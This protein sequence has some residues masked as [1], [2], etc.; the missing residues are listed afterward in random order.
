MTWIYLPENYENYPFSQDTGDTVLDFDSLESISE[1][2]A[3][4]RTIPMPNKY[5]NSDL[6]TGSIP[7]QSGMT[8]TPLIPDPG[9]DTLTSSR[10]GSL[11]SPIHSPGNET[12]Q[13]TE[14]SGPKHGMSFGWWDATGSCLRTYQASFLE[15]MDD[16]PT[17]SKF[18]ESFPSWGLMLDGEFIQRMRRVPLICDRGGL[19]W[20]TPTAR[21]HKD[22]DAHSCAN[23]PVNGLLGRAIHQFSNSEG[24]LNPDWVEAHLMSLPEGWTRLEPLPEGAYE[25]WWDGME[26]GTWWDTERNLPRLTI[27]RSARAKRLKLLGNG[28][29]PASAALAINEMKGRIL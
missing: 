21:D 23:V 11:A 12:S 24:S 13:T 10:Q 18:W 29:V 28:I 3:M 8:S 15:M 19:F 6:E 2:S 20:P 7:L 4:S 22:G 5:Y 17:A 14:T 26:D 27:T 1:P 25:E 9:E 16:N